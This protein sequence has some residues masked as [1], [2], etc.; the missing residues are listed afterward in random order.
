MDRVT[1]GAISIGGGVALNLVGCVL[2]P[3]VEASHSLVLA[4]GYVAL[5]VASVIAAIIG[6]FRMVTALFQRRRDAEARP[7]KPLA[8]TRSDKPEEPDAAS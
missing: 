1:S 2:G 4:I 6:M 7:V 3:S 8:M 5:M